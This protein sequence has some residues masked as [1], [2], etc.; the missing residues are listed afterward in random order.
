MEEEILKIGN[1]L[2]TLHQTLGDEFTS[3]WGRV[4]EFLVAG[5]QEN[6]HTK[7]FFFPFSSATT[8]TNRALEVGQRRD[9]RTALLE[10]FL[11]LRPLT[12]FG[13]YDLDRAESWTHELEHTFETMECPEE[14]QVRLVVYQLKGQ[15]HGWWRVQRQTHFPGQHLD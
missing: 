4:E 11:C 15:A 13:D 12:F 6:A 5:E 14:D 3:C 2:N 1:Y 10:R 7:P 9:N 8:C